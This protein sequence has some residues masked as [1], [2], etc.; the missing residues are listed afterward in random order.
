MTLP[1]F[2]RI[3]GMALLCVSSA[4]SAADCDSGKTAD[5]NACAAADLKKADGD[6]NSAYN[7]YR[8]RL[9]PEQKEQLKDAQ[10]AWIKFRDA[11][12]VFESSGVKGGSAYQMVYTA[13]L[14]GKTR[15]RLKDI[16]ELARCEDG[17]LS[18]PAW[19]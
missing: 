4:A 2:A 18:C 9:E 12:C 15:T 16:Q 8:R 7:Q 5:L 3:A 6:L 1:T 10:M 11:A 14:A 17:D 13:C 19:K